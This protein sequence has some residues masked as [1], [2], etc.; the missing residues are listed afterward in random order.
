MFAVLIIDKCLQIGALQCLVPWKIRLLA[1][2]P[3]QM[4]QFG[5][6]NDVNPPWLANTRFWR[7]DDV[8]PPQLTNT[9]F[10]RMDI[11]AIAELLHLLL[12]SE[13]E[14]IFSMAQGTARLQSGDTYL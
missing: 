4:L 7:I 13:P 10:W 11:V 3:W 1:H 8:N 9:H 5:N 2:F 12:E 14:G 6:S